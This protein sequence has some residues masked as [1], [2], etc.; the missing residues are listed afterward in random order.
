MNFADNTLVPSTPS[1]RMVIV[2]RAD[3]VICGHSGEARCLAEVALTRGFDDVRIVTWPLDA[4]EA[5]GLP[6]KPLDHLLP[7]SPGIT[8]E[9]PDPVGD[10]RVP[11]GRYLSGLIGRLVELFSDGVPTV[12]MSLY[13][14]PHAI[15]VQEAVQVARR[16]GPARVTTVA[17]AVGS[18]ITNVVRECV[19]TGRFGAAAHILSVYLE[20]DHCVAVS[21]YTKD[22]IV[23]SA[24]TLDDMH[25]TTFAQQCQE[26]IAISYPAVD[27]W[28]YLSLT[29]DRI[30]ETL[31]QR[32]LSRD[33]Y[34]LFLSRIASAKGI[35]DLIDA[36]AKS[37]SAER[38]QLVLAGRGPYE[39]AVVARV[40]AAGLGERVR[41]LTDVDDAE[42]PALMAGSA[43][44]VLPT[45]EQPE[46]VETFGIALVEKALA[47]G[48]PIITCATGG[49]PEAVGDTALLVPQHDPATLQIVLDEVICDWTR[50]QRAEAEQ[51]A[52]AHALQFDRVAVFDRLFQLVEPQA[53]VA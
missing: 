28:P 2:V 6:L 47:G 52:R 48:G 27:S 26:R 53:A 37:R 21:E 12:A 42:K 18:D 30:A 15:A 24:A 35:D 34:V 50:E 51:R 4:L 45:R 14:S 43:A 41:V 32:G 3:P 49:V 20:A 1:R 16:I 25:G 38:V 9:R 33:G 7:Y 31:T 36:Y 13:L 11:D 46:F 10:Y 17:E 39:E 40:A 8:V 23:A 29:E 22:L 44:F 19:T 5:A